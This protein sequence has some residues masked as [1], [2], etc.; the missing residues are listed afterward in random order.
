MAGAFVGSVGWNR[1]V[2]PVD[3]DARQRE[4]ETAEQSRLTAERDQ[5][6]REQRER[7][8]GIAT[9]KTSQIK[10][11]FDQYNLNPQERAKISQILLDSDDPHNVDRCN[12]ECLKIVA[13]KEAAVAAAAGAA[14]RIQAVRDR[15]TPEMWVAL[16]STLRQNSKPNWVNGWSAEDVASGL[17]YEATYSGLYQ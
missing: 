17:A 13:A 15:C 5:K 6:L 8:Q 12:F 16:E 3:S 2:R 14:A 11:L 9:F 1:Q 10:A 4:L 7:A